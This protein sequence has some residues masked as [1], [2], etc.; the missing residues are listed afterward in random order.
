ME[1][2]KFSLTS[3]SQHLSDGS[4]WLPIGEPTQELSLPASVTKTSI[5]DLSPDVEYVVT[6]VAFDE[7]EESLPISG[8]ITRESLSQ[9]VTESHSYWA[10]PGESQNYLATELDLLSHKF[11]QLQC[12]TVIYLWASNQLTSRTLAAGFLLVRSWLAIPDVLQLNTNNWSI[13]V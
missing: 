2:G 5:T 10:H 7:S 3:S 13:T 8:Q 4:F 11:I 6:I 1:T 9:W 12:L